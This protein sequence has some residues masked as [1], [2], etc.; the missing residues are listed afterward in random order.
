[1]LAGDDARMDGSCSGLLQGRRPSGSFDHYGGDET[2]QALRASMDPHGRRECALVSSLGNLAH[3]RAIDKPYHPQS[4]RPSK[5]PPA[6]S[7]VCWPELN[8]DVLYAPYCPTCGKKPRGGANEFAEHVC[9]QCRPPDESLKERPAA[10]QRAALQ[11]MVLEL[12]IP[13]LAMA[14]RWEVRGGR[15]EHG[16]RGA[17]RALA[18][19]AHTPDGRLA[20]PWMPARAYLCFSSR[21]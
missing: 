17:P 8:K 13:A 3:K 1:M 4:T 2:L 20:E 21:R 12:Q 10:T 11:L 7:R 6:R 19:A 14:A 18:A 9:H 5:A 16:G 15:V